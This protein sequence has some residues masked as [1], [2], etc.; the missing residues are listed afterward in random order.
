[1]W[2][3]LRCAVPDFTSGRC[4]PNSLLPATQWREMSQS[5]NKSEWTENTLNPSLGRFPQR[6]EGFVTSSEIEVAPLYTPE[7]L[8]GFDY[9][10]APAIP[11]STP[12]PEAR[13]PP[14]TAAGSGPCAST[15]D[16]R[17]PRSR[18]AGTA[19]CSSRARP[20]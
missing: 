16:T 6:Q 13:S 3:D 17:M 14:C 15:R 4:R 18:T 7:D 2:P 9:G 10:R 19:T 1:M 20:A 5:S 8:E 11:A 12:S